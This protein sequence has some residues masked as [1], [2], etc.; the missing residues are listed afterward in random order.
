M[1]CY[2]QSTGLEQNEGKACIYPL[3][4]GIVEISARLRLFHYIRL[5]AT[6]RFRFSFRAFR[7]LEQLC[8]RPVWMA[9]GSKHRLLS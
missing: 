3:S 6:P 1:C 5:F 9:R 4:I 2:F 8:R 7:A